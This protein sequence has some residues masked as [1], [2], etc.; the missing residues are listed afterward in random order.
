MAFADGRGQLLDLCLIA[1][2]AFFRFLQAS[3]DLFGLFAKGWRV[4]RDVSQ[5]S[6]ESD[7]H[8][9]IGE[10]QS[11]LSVGPLVRKCDQR[12]EFLRR[13]ERR[14]IDGSLIR[15]EGGIDRSHVKPW[16]A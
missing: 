12:G 10:A 8:F 7:V 6:R 5:G 16:E 13:L 11:F 2:Q 4:L 14:L 3:Q 9:V 15:R 1:G